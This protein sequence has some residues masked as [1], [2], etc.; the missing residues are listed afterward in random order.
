[1][2]GMESILSSQMVQT[3]QGAVEKAMNYVSA[4]GE[5]VKNLVGKPRKPHGKAR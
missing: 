3:S 1:M 5:Q 2:L 4:A